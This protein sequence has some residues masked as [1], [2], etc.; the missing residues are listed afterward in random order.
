MECDFPS[1]SPLVDLVSIPKS[2]P[3]RGGEEEEEEKSESADSSLL[4][5][6]ERKLKPYPEEKMGKKRRKKP[7]PM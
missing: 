4:Q 5:L 7:S 6:L 1:F 2:S 3:L